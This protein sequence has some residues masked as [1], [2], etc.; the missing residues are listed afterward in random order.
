MFSGFKGEREH[1]PERDQKLV[2]K[3]LSKGSFQSAVSIVSQQAGAGAPPLPG[4]GEEQ[5]TPAPKPG[6]EHQAQET[7][8][9]HR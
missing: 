9:A 7:F 2:S 5:Q 8:Q 4:N 6:E 3:S 1:I